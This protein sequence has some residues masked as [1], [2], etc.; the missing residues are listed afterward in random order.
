MLISACIASPPLPLTAQSS[1]L[2][3][4]PVVLAV[5]E[6]CINRKA[7]PYLFTAGKQ[8]I[9]NNTQQQHDKQLCLL[10]EKNLS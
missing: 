2:K 10:T 5:Q 3:H 4:N 9:T 7:T 6:M 1:D 8:T